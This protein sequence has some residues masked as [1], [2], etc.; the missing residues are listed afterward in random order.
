MNK[1]SLIFAILILTVVSAGGVF[2]QKC[3]SDDSSIV[4]TIADTYG[5]YPPNSITSDGGSSYSTLKARGYTTDVKFQIC[6]GTYDFTLDL[7][8]STRY[9][10]VLT[11]GGT[12]NAKS[13]NFDRVASVPVTVDSDAFAAFCGGRN[14]DGSIKL[15]TANTS[16][17]DNYAGC[18]QDANGYYFVRRTALFQLLS[19][20]SLRFQDSPYDGGSFGR[21]S[22]YVRVY[23]STA[24]VWTLMA[25]DIPASESP[26]CGPNGSCA[27][28]IYKPNNGP[29]Y[30]QGGMIARFNI[31]LSSS[32]VYP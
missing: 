13:F 12:A 16:S 26:L 15:D 2:G 4:A 22:S 30:V 3:S 29:A 5:N 6:N 8:S 31:S 23:H 17:A 28:R 24:N 1:C 19:S 10:K 7:N 18:G 20:L 27:A 11:P 32:R 14:G 21:G 9:Y 25:E